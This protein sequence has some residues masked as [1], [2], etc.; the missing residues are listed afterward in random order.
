MSRKKASVLRALC[1]SS[2]TFQFV[3]QSMEYIQLSLAVAAL[4]LLL[5]AYTKLIIV[6]GLRR[7]A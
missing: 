4:T 2:V 3:R 1:R 7:F 5:A 6:P